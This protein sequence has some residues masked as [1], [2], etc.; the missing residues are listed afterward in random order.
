MSISRK[1]KQA[2][3]RL[4]KKLTNKLCFNKCLL[5]SIKHLISCNYCY[6]SGK[7]LKKYFS[8]SPESFWIIACWLLMEVSK[9]YLRDLFYWFNQ[10]DKKVDERQLNVDGQTTYKYFQSNIFLPDRK[11][12]YPKKQVK[13]NKTVLVSHH[14]KKEY[15]K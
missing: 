9:Q 2:E 13:Q 15:E 4:T 1:W 12:L 3:V 14:N 6:F 8:V 10:K 7:R 11:T 5:S